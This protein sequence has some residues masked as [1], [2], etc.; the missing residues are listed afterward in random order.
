M[1]YVFFFQNTGD[2]WY[3]DFTTLYQESDSAI[4]VTLIKLNVGHFSSTKAKVGYC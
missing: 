4:L 3:S 2:V 1:N